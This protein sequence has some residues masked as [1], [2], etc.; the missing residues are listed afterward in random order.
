MRTFRPG[1]ELQAPGILKNPVPV[2][3]LYD[4]EVGQ[5]ITLR[6]LLQRH[7]YDS[8]DAV[9]AEGEAA[10]RA[11]GEAAGR[12]KGEVAALRGSIVEV[13]TARDLAIGD[14]VRAEIASCQDAAVLRR[15]LEQAVTAASAVEILAPSS[16]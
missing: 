9:R 4:W 8:L 7:G 15:W 1:E 16:A 14:G 10:G 12:E 5:E 3:A 2:E 11:K 13:F 6:N